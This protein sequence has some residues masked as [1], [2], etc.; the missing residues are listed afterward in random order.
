M[1]LWFS[2][3]KRED[4]TES[5]DVEPSE[6]LGESF[7]GV[8]GWFVRKAERSMEAYRNAQSATKGGTTKTSLA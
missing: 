3:D 4:E 8:G 2:K 5:E 7:T 1:S 6:V